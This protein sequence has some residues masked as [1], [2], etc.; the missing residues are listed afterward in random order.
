M[1][2]LLRTTSTNPDFIQLVKLLDIELAE[3]DGDEH[4]FYDQF[5]KIDNIRYVV[6]A[7]ENEK[8]IACGAIKEY[9]PG[10]IEIKR[11]F[12]DPEFRGKGVA[13]MVLNE[14]VQ[15]AKELNYQKCILETGVR[16]P[17]AIRLYQKN[18]FTSIPNY[19]QY[20]GVVN[21]VCYELELN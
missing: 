4:P 16:Q 18:G 9:A 8:A 12:T 1:P 6:V 21:S 5:N 10:I 20:E 19:G 15:W 2:S 3:R 7:Y 13:T 14:L 11:M 17:D